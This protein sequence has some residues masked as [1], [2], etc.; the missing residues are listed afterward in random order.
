MSAYSTRAAYVK[1]A[2]QFEVRDIPLE[3]P[4][5]GQLLVEVK[6]CGVCGT[7]QHIADRTATNWQSFG[8]EVAGIVREIGEGVTRFKVGDRIA[9]D[10]SAPCGKCAACLP[11]PYGRGRFDLCMSPVSY[12]DF[13]AMGFSQLLLTPEQCAVHIPDHLPFDQ[14]S[15]VEPLGVCVDLVKVA[16]VQTGDH[17]LVIGPGPLGLGAVFLA[18][19]AGAERIYLAGRMS[20]S[21]GRMEAGTALGADTLIAVDQ[22]PLA[23]YDFGAQKPDKILV[24]APPETLPEAIEVAAFGGVIAYIGIAWN[25]RAIIQIDADKLHFQKHSLRA[26]HAWPGVHAPES[27]RWLST[28]PLLGSTLVSHHFGLEE[29]ERAMLTARDNRDQARKVIVTPSQ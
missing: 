28:N 18:Q 10:S 25:K 13:P 1:S 11:R 24:T 2:W 16:N 21:K 7:D 4:K 8:H 14:A 27:V 9:V 6:A 20:S 17:V 12:W 23:Q 29:I 5:P 15:L 19:Q 22:K 26:S 3:A